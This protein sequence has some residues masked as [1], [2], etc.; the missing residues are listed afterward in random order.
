MDDGVYPYAGL[1]QATNGNFYGTTYGGGA[2]G[3]GAIF[4]ITP[5]GTLTTLYN[6]CAQSGCPGELPLA[7]LLQATN[8]DF[9]GTTYAGGANNDGTV[10]SLSVGLGP[11]VQTRPTS[12]KP[13]ARRGKTTAST[14][15]S[16]QSAGSGQV[17][18]A[19]AARF[20]YL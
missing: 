14:R 3:Y 10:F 13:G 6:F 9:Y 18:P 1:V 11:F 17:M 19:A 2:N 7:G 15:A 16:S 4:E 20:R 12:G 8:G 5:S